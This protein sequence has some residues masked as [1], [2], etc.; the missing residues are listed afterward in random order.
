MHPTILQLIR[1][2]LAF[3][4]NLSK[5]YLEF[6]ERILSSLFLTLWAIVL[7]ENKDDCEH[8]AV[9]CCTN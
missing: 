1:G 9:D 7:Q 3:P 8:K 2:N 4:S 5:N 6:I